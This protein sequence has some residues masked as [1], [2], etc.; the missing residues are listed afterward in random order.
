MSDIQP[1]TLSNRELLR[2]GA[3]MTANGGMPVNFQVEVLRRL[4]NYTY[5]VKDT[6][7]DS[8]RYHPDQLELDL[9]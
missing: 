2:I 7:N 1:R 5:G 3:D 9:K 8:A 4:N 6:D